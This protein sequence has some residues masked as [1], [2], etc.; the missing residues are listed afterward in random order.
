MQLLTATESAPA[1]STPGAGSDELLTKDIR[2]VFR[3]YQAGQLNAAGLSACYLLLWQMARFGR[4]FAARRQR[5]APHPDVDRL[6]AEILEQT[7]ESLERSLRDQLSRYHH[8]KVPGCAVAALLHWLDGDPRAQLQTRIPM[9]RTVLDLQCA[10]YRPVTLL[11]GFPRAFEPILGKPDG[12]AFLL[13]DLEHLSKF[14]SDPKAHRQQVG[15]FRAIRQALTT[16]VLD[17]D[18]EDPIFGAAFDYLISDMNTHPIHALK[19]FRAILIDRERRRMPSARR[20][21]R[22]TQT[23]A[24]VLLVFKSL[25]ESW[26]LDACEQ[27]ALLGIGHGHLSATAALRLTTWFEAGGA[28]D[29]PLSTRLGTEHETKDQPLSPLFEASDDRYLLDL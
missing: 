14:I 12:L 26:Q 8:Y 16:R 10:G 9:P 18:G 4:Q 25:A 15:F 21:S 24:G 6:R 1:F 23:Q 11:L 22:D 27:E 17:H 29:S 28:D 2:Q 13:H 20:T 7:G 5:S 19:Y 3:S